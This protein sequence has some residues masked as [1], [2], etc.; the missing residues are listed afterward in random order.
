MHT[1]AFEPS[2]VGQRKAAVARTGGQ[3]D[4]VPANDC[5]VVEFECVRPRIGTQSHHLTRHDDV[6]TELLGLHLGIMR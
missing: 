1:G 4:R 2:N 3:H 6:C 5:A